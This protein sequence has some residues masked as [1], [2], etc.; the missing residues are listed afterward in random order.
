[1]WFPPRLIRRILLPILIAVL[2]ALTVTFALA[3]AIL[4]I[5]A[6][7]GSRRRPLRIAA[8]GLAY[9]LMELTVI[10]AAGA[11]W[12]RHACRRP[13]GDD[14]K[15]RWVLDHQAL[16][17]RALD[18]IVR[19]AARCFEFEVLVTNS[20]QDAQ[21]SDPTPVLLLARHGGIGDSFVLV[22]LLLTTYRRGVRIVLKEAL[23]LDPA[24]D[25][26]LNRLGCVFL[27][28]SSSPDDVEHIV[29]LARQLAS[30]DVLLIFPEGANWTPARRLRIIR[31]LRRDH[32]CEA[33][34]TAELM[35][36]VLP[37]RP[38]GVMACLDANP[39]LHMA[40]AAHA[41]LDRMTT[42]RQVWNALPLKVPM[43]VRF[44]PPSPPPAAPEARLDW[45]TLEWAV[46]DEWV[47]SYHAGTID[48]P[49]ENS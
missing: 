33:A 26:L 21:L 37:P 34:R 16:L 19:A 13:S 28:S 14:L 5:G 4:A 20:S 48:Q 40:V 38:T 15:E 31:R 44:W 9:C 47:D 27:S 29:T 32:H 30:R 7:F 2:V 10:P 6:P 39:Q 43:T 8:F 41:G 1:M 46:V 36:N 45:L 23:Q 3:V 18:S 24:L 35:H 49:K 25:I 42:V 22:H 12:L 11:M 17:A